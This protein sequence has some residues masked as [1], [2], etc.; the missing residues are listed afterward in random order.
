MLI[1]QQGRTKATATK[2]IKFP[3]VKENRETRHTKI[4]LV[5]STQLMMMMIIK[6]IKTGKTGVVFLSNWMTMRVRMIKRGWLQAKFGNKTQWQLAVKTNNSSSNNIIKLYFVLSFLVT[7]KGPL[8]W[9][10]MTWLAFC[11]Q[12]SICS[13]RLCFNSSFFVAVVVVLFF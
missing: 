9:V 8:Q 6:K 4:S 5:S 7:V 11:F 10:S 2:S 13:L 12:F 3:R 1:Y